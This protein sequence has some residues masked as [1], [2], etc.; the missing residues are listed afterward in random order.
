MLCFRVLSSDGNAET[1]HNRMHTSSRLPKSRFIWG[2]A[3]DPVSKP[4]ITIMQ[5][6]QAARSNVCQM[7][8]GNYKTH[9]QQQQQQQQCD[10]ETMVSALYGTK[11]ETFNN[12][13]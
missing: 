9:L 3:T 10:I 7:A 8:C 2:K 12:I 5:S 6:T 1:M 4:F 11:S 13:I